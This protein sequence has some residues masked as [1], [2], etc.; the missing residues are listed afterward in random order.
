MSD[1]HRR[2]YQKFTYPINR[3]WIMVAI[4]NELLAPISRIQNYASF[5]SLPPGG[6]AMIRES[7]ITP[8]RMEPLRQQ[9]PARANTLRQKH[10]LPCV[11]Q[12]IDDAL[13][14]VLQINRFPVGQ[15]VYFRIGR[16]YLAQPLPQLLF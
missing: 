15:Q 5:R 13:R 3:L 14:C 6:T 16:H 11:L 9:P 2:Q 8:V 4:E 7:R 12:Q 10:R 1:L